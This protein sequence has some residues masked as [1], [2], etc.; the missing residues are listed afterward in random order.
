M[1]GGQQHAT[2][3]QSV[4]GDHMMASCMVSER[5]R[6]VQGRKRVEEEGC[7]REI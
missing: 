3:G 2:T 6:A 5:R 1:K 4:S 7:W